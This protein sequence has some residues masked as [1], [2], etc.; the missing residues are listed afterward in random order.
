[1]WLLLKEITMNTNSRRSLERLFYCLISLVLAVS[2]AHAQGPALTTITDTIYRADGAPAAGQLVISWPAFTTAGNRAVAAGEKT[3]TL[4]ANGALSTQLAP[5]EGATPAGSYY[6]VVYKLT[7]GTTATEYWTVPI[8]TPTTVGLIRATVVP[9]QV[10]AQLVTR[11]YVDSVLGTADMVHKAGAETITG[12]KSFAV[13]PTVPTP[14]AGTQAANKAYVDAQAGG[15]ADVMHLSGDETATGVKTFSV[16]AIVNGGSFA[17]TFTGDPTFSGNPTFK[18][19]NGVLNAAQFAGATLEDQVEAAYAALP[20]T[21]GE[22]YIPAG[23]YDANAGCIDLNTAAKPVILSGAGQKATVINFTH[24]G[25]GICNLLPI[26]SS[27]NSYVVIRDMTLSN[28][29][30]ANTGAG[31]NQ[32]GGTRFVAQN[33]NITGYW[34]YCV[35]E[36]QSELTDI[37]Y[38]NCDLTNSGASQTGLWLVNGNEHTAGALG[39]FTNRVSVFR[40]DFNIGSGA[41]GDIGIRDDGGYTHYF[42][43]NNFNGGNYGLWLANVN[44]AVIEGNQF[45]AMDTN[46]IKLSHQTPSGTV[47]GQAFSV[48]ISNNTITPTATVTP[49]DIVSVGTLQIL[50][51]QFGR[52]GNIVTGGS[53]AGTIFSAGNVNS[54]NTTF[55]PARATNHTNLSDLPVGGAI[56]DYIGNSMEFGKDIIVAGSSANPATNKFRITGASTGGTRTVTLADGNSVSVVPDAGAAN[57]FV[58]GI[59]SAGVVTKAQPTFASLSGNITVSQLNSGSGASAG[60]FWRGDGTWA[61]PS[62]S[63]GLPDP[64]SEEWV[65][66]SWCGGL[67]ATGQVGALGWRFAVFG[68]GSAALDTYGTTAGV[69]GGCAIQLRQAAATSGAG[70]ILYLGGPDGAAQ[71]LF[72]ASAWWVQSS[73]NLESTAN[74][75]VRFGKSNNITAETGTDGAFVRYI[76]ATDT[77]FMCEVIKAGI[78]TTSPIGVTPAANTWYKARVE[79]DA[80]GNVTCTVNSSSATITSANTPGAAPVFDVFE[81]KSLTASGWRLRSR[82]YEQHWTGL[83]R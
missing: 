1:L 39:G 72:N 48:R 41:T 19:S 9:S 51:N 62:G 38:L 35:I 14:T 24:T 29:N 77:Q 57:N 66:E 37:D 69:G 33:V 23:T 28:N 31:I 82:Y 46:A 61:T 2:T 25:D 67:G 17:G 53:N 26:N 32:V 20:A 58:T 27:T 59:T 12:A 68:S 34:K 36:D 81:V 5:N 3:L 79:R 70:L 65:H 6:K 80:S 73:I 55:Y 18:S 30:A 21:G 63:S 13:S 64:A 16:G 52:N 11:Q 44:T 76:G 8:T 75:T 56:A 60:T 10:A 4:G 47:K 7:D 54:F 43:G 50:G 22:I 78:T 83:A 49:I 71:S 15:G 40:S 42:V 74:Q 45:E